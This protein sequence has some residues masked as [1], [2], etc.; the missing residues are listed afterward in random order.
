MF[1]ERFVHISVER[2]GSLAKNENVFAFG[3]KAMLEVF[4]HSNGP[5][6]EELAD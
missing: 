4:S 1:A 3:Q 6:H 5:V 2:A